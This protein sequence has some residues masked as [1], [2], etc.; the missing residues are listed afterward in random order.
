FGLDCA[1]RGD[2]GVLQRHEIIAEWPTGLRDVVCD[3]VA[4][5]VEASAAPGAI[6]T[7]VFGVPGG[8]AYEIDRYSPAVEDFFHAVGVGIADFSGVEVIECEFVAVAH[9]GEDQ[10]KAF[11]TLVLLS[12]IL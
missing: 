11:G 6:R 12:P 5:V 4:I 1:R 8:P 10:V 2:K 9:R 3:A 7:N